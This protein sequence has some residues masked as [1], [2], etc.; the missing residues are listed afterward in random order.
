MLAVATY[1]TEDC[2]NPD[3]S[4]RNGKNL[5]LD[6]DKSPRNRQYEGRGGAVVT[7]VRMLDFSPGVESMFRTA[8]LGRKIS[9]KEFDAVTPALRTELITLQQTLRHADFPVV[10]VFAG[11]DGA[12]KGESINLLSEWLDPRWM[13]TS[14]YGDPSDE[15]RERPSAWRYW[16]DLPPRGCIG[17]FMGSWYS[18]PVMDRAWERIS[19]AEMDEQLARIAHFEKMLADDGAL[20]LKFWMHLG[21]D[22]QR[23]RLRKLEKK[24]HEAWR[25]TKRDWKH[26]EMYD[27]FI[28]AAE[29]TIRM[30]SD[31]HA[32]WTIIEGEDVRYR[33]LTLL[34]TLRD[35][36]VRHLEARDLRRKLLETVKK[37]ENAVRA[38]RSVPAAAKTRKRAGAQADAGLLSVSLPQQPTILDALDMSLDLEPAEYAERIRAGRSRLAGLSRL[39]RAYGVSSVLVFE[40]WDAGGKGGA[41]R[42]VVSALDAREYKVIPTAAPTDEEKARHYLWRFWRHISR[43]GRV[44][45]YD[46]SWYGRVLV[47]RVEGFARTDEWMRAYAEI[48]AFEEQLSEFGTVLC[49]YWLHITPEE[50]MARFTA[51]QNTPWK[52]WKL[53]DEDWR[54][55]EK[56][57]QYQDAVNDMIERTSTRNAPWTLVEANSKRYARVKVLETYTDQLAKGLKARG[58]NLK[59]ALAV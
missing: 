43:A 10:L 33:S 40:G 46:R 57:D 2:V 47:E 26:W 28:A 37:D 52:A 12:G 56:W 30:T 13:S 9:R 4:Q 36:L 29:R 42:R 34:M 20:I 44:T 51:R 39:A 1:V 49:K 54:N 6:V 41:I 8:E 14:A 50:Q 22:A 17:M 24:P 11:V 45:I 19:L 27:N 58:I 5:I 21:R 35:A 18:A 38:G 48:N 31:G 53:T 23:R 55:R 25:V 32:P 3:P 15:E 7:A 16:R 59:K